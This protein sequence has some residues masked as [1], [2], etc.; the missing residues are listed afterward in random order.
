MS[1]QGCLVIYCLLS[2]IMLC[3]VTYLITLNLDIGKFTTL[4]TSNLTSKTHRKQKL[5][6]KS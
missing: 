3:T 6:E 1:K 5:V 2:N 4:L